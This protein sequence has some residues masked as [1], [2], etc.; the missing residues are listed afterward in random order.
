LNLNLRTLLLLSHLLMSHDDGVVVSTGNI[1]H[2]FAFVQV[3]VCK[4]GI[5][6]VVVKVVEVTLTSPSIERTLVRFDNIVC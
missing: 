3:H 2:L 4:L 5:P 6:K 1:L